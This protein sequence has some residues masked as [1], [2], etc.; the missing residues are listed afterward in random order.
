M[1]KFIILILFFV[2][3]I[4]IFAQENVWGITAYGGTAIPTGGFADFY[5]NGYTFSGGAIYSFKFNTRIAVTLGYSRWSLDETAFNNAL[6]SDSLNVSFKGEAP[7]RAIPLLLQVKW[8]GTN[9]G[10]KPYAL[11]EGGFYFSKSEFTGE[12]FEADTL[13]GN[14]SGSNSS[15]NT[16]ITLG[17]GLSFDLFENAEL[18]VAGRYHI[19]S[20]NNSYNFVPV[21]LGSTISSEQYWSVTAGINIILIE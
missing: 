18:D 15:T 8:Y 10:I 11:I 4:S 20:L 21:N 2:F 13:A 5:N 9:E 16:G 6:H 19:V 14:I 7:V 3:S 12:V 1:K 17:L